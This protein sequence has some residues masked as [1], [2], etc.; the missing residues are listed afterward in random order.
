MI[1]KSNREIVA[2][3]E[4]FRDDAH[5]ALTA[6]GGDPGMIASFGFENAIQ[7]F[8]GGQLHAINEFLPLIAEAL[9]RADGLAVRSELGE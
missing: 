8:H 2:A 7:A 9:G 4:E 5:E 1:G 6:Q 3:L